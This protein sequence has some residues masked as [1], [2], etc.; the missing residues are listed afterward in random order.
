MQRSKL[1]LPEALAK[2]GPRIEQDFTLESLLQIQRPDEISVRTQKL[3]HKRDTVSFF[4]KFYITG[5]LRVLRS[6]KLS[7]QDGFQGMA[8]VTTQVPPL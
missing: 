8:E 7:G 6:D 2:Y 1:T 5:F 4:D 3:F